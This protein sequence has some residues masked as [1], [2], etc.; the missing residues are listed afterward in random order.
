MVD[1]EG[2]SRKTNRM[3]ALLSSVPHIRRGDDR[4]QFVQTKIERLVVASGGV[5]TGLVKR[6]VID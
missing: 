6:R 4:K 2:K 5:E 3:D 1:S